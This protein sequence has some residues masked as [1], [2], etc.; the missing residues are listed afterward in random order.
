MR[1]YWTRVSKISWS[2][3]VAAAIV[4]LTWTGCATTS[5]TTPF[6]LASHRAE[7][8]APTATPSQIAVPARADAPA[9]GGY[10]AQFASAATTRPQQ[11][12]GAPSCSSG[13]G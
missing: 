5:G 6:S 13:A 9:P 12:Y 2:F 11:R 4:A 3:Q 1:I 10:Q 8:A 7:S